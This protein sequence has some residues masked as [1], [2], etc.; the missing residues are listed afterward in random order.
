[1]TV[2]GVAKESDTI[3][4]VCMC[5]FPEVSY[6]PDQTSNPAK[7]G[8]LFYKPTWE[9]QLLVNL[10]DVKKTRKFCKIVLMFNYKII[11]SNKRKYHI[12]L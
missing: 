1:M 5:S 9:T 2:H 11:S 3:A 12:Q 6:L 8:V 7:T 4:H 10:L